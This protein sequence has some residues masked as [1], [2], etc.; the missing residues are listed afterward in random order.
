[1]TIF[2]RSEQQLLAIRHCLRRK[3]KYN[4]EILPMRPQLNNLRSAQPLLEGALFLSISLSNLTG[5]QPEAQ[6]V[7]RE[8]NGPLR[9]KF[10]KKYFQKFSELK[11]PYPAMAVRLLRY[12]TICPLWWEYCEDGAVLKFFPS[13]VQQLFTW[14]LASEYG[15]HIY[16]VSLEACTS[17]L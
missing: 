1:M 5:S 6:L 16:I 4:H 2:H 7:K 3:H 17:V 12:W 8:F 15:K 9:L 14:S 11:H 13:Y 10:R